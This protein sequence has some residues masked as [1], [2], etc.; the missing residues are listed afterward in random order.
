MLVVA[1][2]SP[3]ILLITIGNVEILPK[4]FKNVVVPPD[5]LA[6]RGLA[7]TAHKQCPVT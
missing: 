5:V 4:L 6:A 3:F 7:E 1:D 2:S